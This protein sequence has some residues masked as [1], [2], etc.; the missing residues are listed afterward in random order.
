MLIALLLAG[1][2][3]PPVE[4]VERA[5]RDVGRAVAHSVGNARDLAFGPPP[6]IHAGDAPLTYRCSDDPT[7]VNR[8]IPSKLSDITS[9]L[10][11]GA[12]AN[13]THDDSG[14]I[15]KTML[16]HNGSVLMPA[17]SSCYNIGSTTLT[18]PSG[19]KLEGEGY[20]S[21]GNGAT[22]ITY[23]GSGCAILF[24]SVHDAGLK[25]IDIQL[26]SASSTAAGVCWKS[27]SSV[28]EFNVVENVS[29]SAPTRVV[30]QI[31]F[32]VEDT[33]SGVFWSHAN[34]MWFKGLDTAF[35]AHSTGTTQGV[36]SNTFT[37]F[38]VYASNTGGRV[39][40]GNKQ[41]SDNDISIT[42][43]RSDGTLTGNINCLML[44]DDNVAGVFANRAYVRNDTGAPSV[45]G[46]LG[47]T[48]AANDVTADCE[49]GGGFQ[50]NGVG[51]FSNRVYNQT[52][53]G[54]LVGLLS[55]G[56]LITTRGAQIIGTTFLGING[57]GSG[58]AGGN[59]QV[60]AGTGAANQPGGVLQLSGGPGGAGNAKGG[61]AL[62]TPGPQTGTGTGGAA[63]IGPASGGGAGSGTRIR[64]SRVIVDSKPFVEVDCAG[65]NLGPTISQF[66]DASTFTCGTTQTI[67]TITA[68]AIVAN[69]PGSASF[70]NGAVAVGDSFDLATIVATG[71]AN[72]TLVAG[73]GVTIKGNAVANNS[74]L[75]VRC[76]LTNITPGSEAVTC[77]PAGGGVSVASA[78]TWTGL[79]T[80]SGRATISGSSTRENLLLTTNAVDPSTP[81]IGGV[82]SFDDG[83]NAT[84]LKFRSSG[85][86]ATATYIM[87]PIVANTVSSVAAGSTINLPSNNMTCICN[88]TTGTTF[89]PCAVSGTTL[90]I[91]AHTGTVPVAYHCLMTQ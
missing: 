78:N 59:V 82:W 63:I 32:W 84:A 52:S 72:F 49:S 79:Q 14:A 16:A 22:C 19:R 30:G 69:L 75:V 54:S 64:S 73:S 29:V 28:D 77:F 10:D 68:A 33:G 35:F 36:N 13:G 5:T 50:D 45:C 53:L 85:G 39:L 83:V 70:T 25:N 88:A 61:D 42:C 67:Q 15:N 3:M 62:L 1:A 34:R 74:T 4:V 7:C 87:A 60:G 21:P 40:A 76:R 18:I 17:S 56:N 6:V 11:K 71:T 37:N 57:G 20:G 9:V 12:V 47:T 89:I 90:S 43:S 55:I 66:L 51:T 86:G 23:T 2:V 46:V 31:G 8:T 91:A 27:T 81:S 41:A 44:G 24:D 26:N 48:A 80:F 38:F 65:A 58:G